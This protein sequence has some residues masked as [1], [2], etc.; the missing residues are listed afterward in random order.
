MAGENASLGP[1]EANNASCKA[2][3]WQRPFGQPAMSG[4][5]H[6]PHEL[7]AVCVTTS[8]S[9][10]YRR[11]VQAKKAQKVAPALLNLAGRP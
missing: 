2:H 9:F 5:P 6:V 4:A 8:S 10:E 7:A 1:M 11:F 3:C